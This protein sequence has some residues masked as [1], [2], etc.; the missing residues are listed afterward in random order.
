MTDVS[1]LLHNVIALKD[2]HFG[3]PLHLYVMRIGLAQL[4]NMHRT[5][6]TITM[7]FPGD[8]WGEDHILLTVERLLTDN[9][10]QALAFVESQEL[11]KESFDRTM[12]SYP[13]QMKS[14]R[15]LTLKLALRRTISFLVEDQRRVKKGDETNQMEPQCCDSIKDDSKLRAQTRYLLLS[16]SSDETVALKPTPA[17]QNISETDI[18]LA[19]S[20]LDEVF[21]EMVDL[22]AR[23]DMVEMSI[24]PRL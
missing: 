13:D 6:A 9:S 15:R 12:E 10:A 8:V 23:L 3:R 21:N 22:T 14:F 19:M 24:C 11:S 17:E 7:K 1:G 5:K 2:E 18:Q 4:N 16:T 20:R